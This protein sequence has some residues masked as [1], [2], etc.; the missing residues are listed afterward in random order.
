MDRKEIWR[1]ISRAFLHILP[2]G[3]TTTE[4]FDLALAITRSQ[5]ALDDEISEAVNGLQKSASLVSKLE[6]EVQKRASQLTHLQSEHA[7]LSALSEVTAKQVK[8]LA[9]QIELSIGKA[10]RWDAVKSLVIS[11]FAGTIIFLVGIFASDWIRT[12]FHMK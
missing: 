9:N 10:R 3:M 5:R 4:L 8:A 7:R 12:I 2:F 6:S 1:R 11:L